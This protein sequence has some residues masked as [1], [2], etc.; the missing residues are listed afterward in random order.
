M[1]IFYDQLLS[2]LLLGVLGLTGYSVY[3]WMEKGLS[4]VAG[5]DPRSRGGEVPEVAPA[6]KK[7][8]QWFVG[9]L[10]DFFRWLPEGVR[11]NDR[12]GRSLLRDAMSKKTLSSLAADF[13]MVVIISL[14]MAYYCSAKQGG[15]DLYMSTFI[16]LLGVLALIFWFTETM[17]SNRILSFCVALLILVGISLQILLK[18]PAEDP[19]AA[20]EL[21]IYAL[22]SVIIGLIAVPIIRLFCCEMRRS[23]AV[24]LLNMMVVGIYLL[25]I[26]AGKEINGTK[27]WLIVAGRSFQLTE[28]TKM[29]SS[30]IF[31]LQFT[32]ETV[33]VK[34]AVTAEKKSDRRLLN[35]LITL[36][37]NA[38]FLFVI[39]EFG[40]LCVL[41]L[42]FF[43]LAMVYL[44]SVKKLLA[45]IMACLIAASIAL[46]GCGYC[47]DI[48][49]AEETVEVTE[50]TAETAPDASAPAG[51]EAPQQKDHG[52]IVNLGAR[53]YKKF[54]I[55]MDL[56]FAPETVDPY[57]E[58]YQTM[59]ARAALLM[60]GWLGSEYEV[61]IPVV[62]S[63]FIFAYLVMK[64]GMIFGILVIVLLLVMLCMGS[65]G[66]LKNRNNAEASVGLAFLLAIT[67]QSLVAAASASGLFIM[68]G[69]PFAFLAEGGSA[70]VMNYVMVMYLLYVIR[71]KEAHAALRTRNGNEP[72]ARKEG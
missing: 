33:T 11:K 68:I 20:S 56:I 10:R 8:L 60:A 52:K 29:L 32:D 37:I 14:V 59:K 66:C 43:V 31:A 41:A 38:A 12:V 71:G 16:P 5:K 1:E 25:L 40:T 62:S 39:N 42:V 63:N 50:P 4:R 35:A 30:A 2:L 21:V 27:A 64:M 19:G 17:K 48:K 15:L 45:M 26:V 49:Y 44:V 3:L 6:A 55:R 54:K 69:M 61:S 47:Y 22:I 34:G 72:L 13:L 57:N 24:F 9:E 46:M 53:I 36:A 18:L 7:N 23:H 28:V 51:E 65:M 58:G 70:S 67:L